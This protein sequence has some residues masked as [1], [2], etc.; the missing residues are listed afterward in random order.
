MTDQEIMTRL[1]FEKYGKVAL[2]V[3]ETATILGISRKA[4][5]KDRYEATGIP[6]T[7][8]TDKIKG[9][10]MYSITTITK[11]LIQNQIKTI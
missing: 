5:E 10:V 2:T 1:L 6:F 7:R 11:H 9:Q 3:E 4:L 8:R